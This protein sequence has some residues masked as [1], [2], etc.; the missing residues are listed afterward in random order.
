MRFLLKSLANSESLSG[1]LFLCQS[2][3]LLVSSFNILGFLDD[4]E[5]D[6]AVGSQVWRDSTVGSVGS[7]S[8][9]DG[10]LGGNVSDLASFDI[11]TF[12]LG[13]GL[14]VLK[15]GDNV[16]NRLLWESTVVMIEVLADGMS[17]WSSS[18]S[19]E[20]NDG[21]MLED[22][23]HILDGLVQVETS[24]GSRSLVGV[25]IVGSQVVNSAFS[26][27]KKKK[28]RLISPQHQRL[29]RELNPK[30][31]CQKLKRRSSK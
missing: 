13:V 27:Y 19:S 23:L 1:G 4:V 25:L 20:W 3:L 22:A 10:S 9:L 26:S 12:E 15:Q 30:K 24:A 17:S 14:Q 5:F 8:S 29:L 31:S 11:K 2:N 18:V 6:V 16:S 7:S 28:G 21:G